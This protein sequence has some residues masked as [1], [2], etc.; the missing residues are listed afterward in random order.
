M[1][2]PCEYLVTSHDK[3]LNQQDIHTWKNKT[4]SHG[5]TDGPHKENLDSDNSSLKDMR[6]KIKIGESCGIVI[7]N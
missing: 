2:Y 1:I 5:T 7:E 6:W 4:R 3:D